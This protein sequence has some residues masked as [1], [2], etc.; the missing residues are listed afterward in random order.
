MGPRPDRGGIVVGKDLASDSTDG[1][2]AESLGWSA[3]PSPALWAVVPSELEIGGV[4][5]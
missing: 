5:R 3:D 2:R 4:F 1:S